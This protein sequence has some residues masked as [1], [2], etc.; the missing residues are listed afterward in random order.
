MQV[1]KSELLEDNELLLDLLE[2]LCDEITAHGIA[3]SPELR[4]RIDAFYAPEE[5]N[6][7]NPVDEIGRDIVI[8]VTPEES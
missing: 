5:D 4:S 6:P 3:I 7:D 1:T 2:D 8:D